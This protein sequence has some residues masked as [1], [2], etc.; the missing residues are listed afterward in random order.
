MNNA[1]DIP[2]QIT[3]YFSKI[4]S[5]EIGFL[6]NIYENLFLYLEAIINEIVAKYLSLDYILYNQMKLENLFRDYQWNDIRLNDI[7]SNNL[8]IKLKI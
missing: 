3:D 6:D 4:F 2:L 8:I 7:K 5:F 1:E